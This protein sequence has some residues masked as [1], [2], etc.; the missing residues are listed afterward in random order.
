MG[1]PWQR[2]Q[3][4][5]VAVWSACDFW[6]AGSRFHRQCA[7]ASLRASVCPGSPIP[8]SI[9]TPGAKRCLLPLEPL[10]QGWRR[11]GGRG[12][13]SLRRPLWCPRPRTCSSWRRAGAGLQCAVPPHHHGVCSSR[14]LPA[15]AAAVRR[16]TCQP[17]PTHTLRPALPLS[18]QALFAAHPYPQQHVYIRKGHGF[19]LLGSSV[20]DCRHS[21]R[22]LILPHLGD[23]Q[24]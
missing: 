23:S 15:A 20:E 9:C 2:A 14:V 21:F 22:N 1:T 10:M 3:V 6:Q 18:L 11:H 7:S 17:P 13:P 24:T 4:R 16:V 12:L 8:S 5:R 19:F